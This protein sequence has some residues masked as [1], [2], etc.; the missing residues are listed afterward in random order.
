MAKKQFFNVNPSNEFGALTLSHKFDAKPVHSNKAL[1]KFTLTGGWSEGGKW[2][3]EGIGFNIVQRPKTE[4]VVITPKGKELKQIKNTT[5]IQTTSGWID[6]QT[7]NKSANTLL[8]MN[9]QVDQFGNVVRGNNYANPDFYAY[10]REKERKSNL[11]KALPES[12]KQSNV[13]MQALGLKDKDGRT[14]QP[15]GKGAGKSTATN[16]RG[17]SVVYGGVKKRNRMRRIAREKAMRASLKTNPMV[18]YANKLLEEIEKPKIG[19]YNQRIGYG[20]RYRTLYTVDPEDVINDYYLKTGVIDYAKGIDPE[21]AKLDPERKVTV[22][23]TE[24]SRRVAQVWCHNNRCRRTGYR[25]EY[26]RTYKDVLLSSR[27]KYVQMDTLYGKIMDKSKEKKK[28]Y[29]T[30]YELDADTPDYAYYGISDDSFASYESYK[31]NLIS[32]IDARRE[33]QEYIIKDIGTDTKSIDK[34]DRSNK[35]IPELEKTTETLDT[36]ASTLKQQIADFDWQGK[37]RKETF[38]SDT[39]TGDSHVGHVLGTYDGQV[40]GGNYYVQDVGRLIKKTKKYE[41]EMESQIKDTKK[42]IEDIEP[43]QTEGL[44]DFYTDVRDEEYAKASKTYLTK[45]LDLTRKE[46]E[47]LEKSRK[48]QAFGSNTAARS[49][50]TSKQSRG[51]PSLKSFSKKQYRNTRTRGGKN[52]LGGL[53]I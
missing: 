44:V 16:K 43:D 21:H 28:K 17:E 30:Y 6:K 48:A 5:G 19:V 29:G 23:D 37:I 11:K 14:I 34:K 25:T 7:L 42:E 46:R 41:E 10:E 1:P 31:Q 3:N 4:N 18:L 50:Y 52:T 49:G 13:L 35:L 32:S 22:I 26:D 39:I 45:S 27:P 53:V 9:Q 8:G 15:G 2:K 51:R 33:N 47:Q 12:I 24:T 38:G 20:V 40:R 36:K